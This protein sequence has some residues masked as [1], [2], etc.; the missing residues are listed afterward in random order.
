MSESY[1]E[2]NRDAILAKNKQYY[3][4]NVDARSLYNQKYYEKKRGAI[5]ERNKQY[6]EDHLQ[7]K[8]PYHKHY[9][10]N[11]KELCKASS[12]ISQY[13]HADEIKQ[14]RAEISKIK[15]NCEICGGIY[16]K[17]TESQHKNTVMHR[18]A[19]RKQN[20]QR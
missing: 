2:K 4:D 3:R 9:Y 8:K 7:E 20:G 10:E 13:E 14:R 1:Y 11:N 15:F 5:I 6:Y 18:R 17:F 12:M 19:V 16:S